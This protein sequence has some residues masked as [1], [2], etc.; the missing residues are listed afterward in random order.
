MALRV[1]GASGELDAEQLEALYAPP[2]GPWR[3]ANFVVTVDGTIELGGRAGPLADADDKQV[4]SALRAVADV[5]LVGAE[6]VRVEDYGPA[7]PGAATRER[8]L[9]RGQLPRP[10]VAVVT[11]SA[12]LDPGGRL[13]TEGGTDGSWPRPIVL[14]AGSA[15]AGRRKALAEVAEVVVCGDERVDLSA[16]MATLQ[17]RG[18]D[19]VLCEGGPT[20]LSELLVGGLLDEL[21]LTHAAI[22]AGPGHGQLVGGPLPAPLQMERRTVLAGDTALFAS[23]RVTGGQG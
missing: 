7:R 20:L 11:A 22:V 17:D 9:G 23:Y 21:C 19:Q 6:T 4:F 16:T 2:P 12:K 18:L 1:P 15:D 5:V 3:R 14:T 8:R 10:P 13:F